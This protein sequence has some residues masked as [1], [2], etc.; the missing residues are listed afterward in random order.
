MALIIE[1][2]AIVEG[3][4]SYASVAQARAYA[5]ARGITLP[6]GDADVEKLLVKACDYIDSQE[7]R[8]KGERV[9]ADQPLAWPRSGV[10]L[11][12]SETEFDRESIPAQLIKAQCQLAF[13]AVATDLQPTGTGREVVREKVDV[14]ETE[15]A[16]T[17]S[18]SVTPELNK[19]D[20]ILSPLFKNQGGFALR[21]LRV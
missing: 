20:A 1:T 3:A 9:S 5:E 21:T 10:F 15:Y 17:G 18:G 6:A 8:F 12:A 16:K 14:I 4:N 13:D 11:F 2:G 19:A 7:E